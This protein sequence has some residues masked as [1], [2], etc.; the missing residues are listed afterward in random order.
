MKEK[1]A[2]FKFSD[3]VREHRWPTSSSKSEEKPQ[4]REQVWIRV[5]N[6]KYVATPGETGGY[7]LG[8]GRLEPGS[9][10]TVVE[11]EFGEKALKSTSCVSPP[12]PREGC[13]LSH[14][15]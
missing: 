11:C 3:F 13:C 8:G 7:C 15:P 6:I 5:T 14:L 9:A 10:H 4:K 12:L 1:V 2:S